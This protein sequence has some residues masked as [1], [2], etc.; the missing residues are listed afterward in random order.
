VA[1][2]FWAILI[3]APIAI[4][5]TNVPGISVS[6]WVPSLVEDVHRIITVASL[7]KDDV[8]Y[9]LGCGNGRLLVAAYKHTPCKVVGV[10]CSP[11]LVALT[12]LNFLIKR[13]K[14]GKV[15]L[16][17]FF[18]TSLKDADVVLLFLMPKV[19]DKLQE[20]L[21]KEMKSGARIVSYTFPFED[22][23][24]TAIDWPKDKMPVYLY[25]IP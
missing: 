20:K 2:Y 10:D 24:A 16:Q 1:W 12:K 7:K 19:M 4:L 23:E 14:G 6:P 18:N 3:G 5:I 25:V 8:V 9:D 11:L 13:I 21:Q 22:W 17:S 15:I